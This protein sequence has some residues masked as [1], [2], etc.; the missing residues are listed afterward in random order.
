MHFF[1]LFSISQSFLGERKNR[2]QMLRKGQILYFNDRFS[3]AHI[4]ILKLVVSL[5]C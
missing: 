2:K 4:L 1:F 5:Q 3:L